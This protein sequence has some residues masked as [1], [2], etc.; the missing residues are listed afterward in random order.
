MQ[1]PSH[2]LT[3]HKKHA[4]LLRSVVPPAV[5]GLSRAPGTKICVRSA[6]FPGIYTSVS[7]FTH[8]CLSLRKS[9]MIAHLCSIRPA[10]LRATP[11]I[12]FCSDACSY[13]HS[14]ARHVHLPE[15]ISNL[16]LSAKEK[17]PF[18]VRFMQFNSP[19]TASPRS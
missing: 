14:Q 11:N 7:L 17:F 8:L 9:L 6:P 19:K 13:Q 15:T 5:Q 16:S 3:R 4:A 12:R 2:H 1:H 10:A 18:P